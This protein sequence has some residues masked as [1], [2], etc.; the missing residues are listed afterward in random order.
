VQRF[1]KATTYR[2]ADN[3]GLYLLV[4]P[5][6][7]KLWHWNYRYEQKQKTI[8]FGKYPDVTLKIARERH[9][10]A[11]IELAKGHDPMAQRKIEKDATNAQA[12]LKQAKNEETGD[13]HSF[14][15]VSLKWHKWWAAGV[16]NGTEAY[17]LRRLEAD[18]F[19]VLGSKSINAIKPADV[20][21]LIIAIEQGTGEVRR[22]KGKW[23]RDVAQRQHGTISQIFRF[24][25]AHD[26]AENNPAAAFRP[27]NILQPR[28]TQHRARIEPIMFTRLLVAI[29]R[30]H[31]RYRL[32]R[33]WSDP[34]Q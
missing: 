9:A 15:A 18:V 7:G 2:P 16:D 33:V 11:R 28:R 3:G 19:P 32:R 10:A 20:R 25:I 27:S 23:A 8:S 14:E 30:F 26:L 6:G 5:A 21:N 4:S 1:P 34:R 17:I 12:E 29:D 22:F 13:P 24:A 31:I